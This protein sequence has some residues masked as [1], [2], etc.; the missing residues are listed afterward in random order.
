MPFVKTRLCGLPRALN[1]RLPWLYRLIKRSKQ[2][3]RQ[4]NR[5]VPHIQPHQLYKYKPLDSDEDVDRLVKII[6]TGTIYT[7]PI[8]LLNDP[9]EGLGVVPGSGYAGVSLP[10]AIEKTPLHFKKGI[11]KCRVISLT[12]NPVS[13]QMWAYYSNNYKGACFRLDPMSL[14]VEPMRYA[15]RPYRVDGVRVDSRDGSSVERARLLSKHIDWSHEQEWRAIYTGN[16]CP[17]FVSLGENNPNAVIL[18]HSCM[19]EY[20]KTI[21]EACAEVNIPVYQTYVSDWKYCLRIVPFGFKAE[22]SGASLYAQAM[23][24]CARQN[25]PM[26][27]DW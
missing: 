20:A 2:S 3:Q 4:E 21:C 15:A 12:E 27:E 24:E 16:D 6:T 8:N 11:S 19:P 18:G 23:Q 17:E 26:F 9:F 10:K 1:E 13:P 22:L 7:S 25:I 14:N 5:T